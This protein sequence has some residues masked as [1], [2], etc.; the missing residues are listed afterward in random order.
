MVELDAVEPDYSLAG[1]DAGKALGFDQPGP[2][3]RRLR[4][5]DTTLDERD[6]CG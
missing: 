3:T 2:R 6:K 5:G 4:L 1:N